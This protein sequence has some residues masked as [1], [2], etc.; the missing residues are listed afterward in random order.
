MAGSKITRFYFLSVAGIVTAL[1][2]LCAGDKA[3][4]QT[5]PEWKIYDSASMGVSIE[6]PSDWTVSSPLNWQEGEKFI[7]GGYDSRI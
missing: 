1:F 3:I 5:N 4:A 6:H 7:V 2:L